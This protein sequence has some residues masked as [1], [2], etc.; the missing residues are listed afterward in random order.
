MPRLW[1][2]T[3]RA[4]RESVRDAILDAVAALTFERG[5]SAVTMS[6]VA[7][8]S[9]IGRA[10]LYKYFPDVESMLIAWHERQVEAHLDHLVA[11]RDRVRGSAGDALAA[12]LSA[13]ADMSRQDHGGEWAALLHRGPHMPRAHERLRSFVRD[14]VAEGARAGD[15]R[16]DV[17]PDELAVYCLHAL[18]AA[19]G[20]TS[21]AAVRRLVDVTLTG[22]RRH[23][24]AG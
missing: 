20:L 1:S 6:E 9:G 5:L 16:D 18:S 17:A 12:V 13:Y 15:L 8:R 19:G 7:E 4:H 14:L 24:P 22:L 3:I 11:V 10:T 21:R 2:D 23:P